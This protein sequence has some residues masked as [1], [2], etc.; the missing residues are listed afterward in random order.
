MHLVGF[1]YKDMR[2]EYIDSH[3]ENSHREMYI[4]MMYL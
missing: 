3:W 4:M 2:V 1:Y